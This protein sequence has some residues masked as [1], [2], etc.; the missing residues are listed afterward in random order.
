MLK[1]PALLLVTF[2]LSV[3]CS[4]AQH[5]TLSG[6]VRDEKNKPVGYA[7][8]A[9][10]VT[11]KGTYTNDKGFYILELDAAK[12]LSVVYGFTG[13][14]LQRVKLSLKEGQTRTLD[15]TLKESENTLGEF[16]KIDD[17]K[18]AEAGGVYLDPRLVHFLPSPISGIES[19]IK[20][21]VGSHN[22]LTSQYSVRGGSYDE[23]LVYVNDFEIYRPF[24]VRAGQQ[25]GLSFINT[26]LVSNVNFSVGGFQARYGDKMSSV[27][28]VSYKRPSQFAG[29]VS[30]SLL[31]GS[32]HLEGS[33]KDRRLTYLIGARQKTNQ[34]LL[35]AQPTKGV[36]N[37]S[38][39]DLQA[40]VNYKIA[41][42]WEVEA[43]ANYARNRFTFFP[44]TMV[45]SFGVLNQAYQLDVF[46]NGS[47]FDQ[48]DSRFGG[49]SA[50]YHKDSSH[51]KLKFLASAFQTN[52]YET[53]DINGQYLFG[54]LQTDQSKKDYG[55]IKTY[56]G[57]GGI[58]DFAR[59][60]LNVS[61]GDVGI[62]G[63]VDAKKNFI[64]F[65]ANGTFTNISD[66]LHQWQRRDSAAFT[67][68]YNEDSLKLTYFFNSGADFNYARINGFIQDNIHFD[69]A[70]RFTTTVGVRFSYSGL[71]NEF[72][73]SPRLQ[74]GYKPYWKKDFVFKASAGYYNQ[75]PF[76][77]E[78]RDLQ[79]GINKQLK[80]QK[81]FQAVLGTDYN[82]KMYERPFKITAETYY[83]DLW[84]LDPYFFDN[85]R[86]RYTGKNDAVGHVY[87]GELRLYGDL[88]KDATSWMSIGILKG[89]QK[90][91][92][93]NSIPG[94]KNYFP[95]PSD[96][97]FMLGMYFEDYLP[98]NKNFKVHLNMIYATGLPVGP[99]N[100][101]LYQNSLRIPDYKRVDI[102]FSALLLDAKR[103]EHP[104]HSFFNNIKSIWASLEVFNMLSIQNTLSYTWIQD[105]T[106][107][108]NY[109]VPNR[110]TSRLINVKMVINF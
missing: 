10:E 95:L 7:Y 63:S 51:F 6:I 94:Y 81:S 15:I 60:Y 55:Q 90:I 43:I 24:L 78:M 110:L 16:V 8:V 39:T 12:N 46:Y 80:A 49:I 70:N 76:Y 99:P 28:D 30:M 44:E 22:E 33:T 91:T 102:G 75:P 87:G 104:A 108:L 85:V 84:D 2:L 74:L 57:T 93:S 77:R 107:G 72:L 25:E 105:W 14:E 89:E 37:P 20:L 82:F 103:K 68:P 26:D 58:Q 27:L 19:L 88:V 109:A 92:D 35:Q 59:N 53:Y 32:L 96:Q 61:V 83:K 50:T 31:G 69:S 54:E 64:Q 36:Y 106:S 18:R 73:V 9:E 67:Q 71:N 34:Y 13:Y 1:K 56:L 41:K 17:R 21:A 62:R 4:Y 5:A 3:V 97:R 40:L 42:S 47:E 86:I 79:G 101:H 11:G 52:E 38:F 65:G 23:N 45:A 48:F 29:S 100:G 98:R 66:N